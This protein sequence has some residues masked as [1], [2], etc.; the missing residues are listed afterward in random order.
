M[1]GN[2]SVT[3]KKAAKARS[4]EIDEQI[5]AESRRLKREYKVLV[6]GTDQPSLCTLVNQMK[7]IHQGGLSETELTAF[8]PVVHKN[9]MESAYEALK[10]MR[11]A[12]LN[13]VDRSNLVLA[14]KVLDFHVATLWDTHSYISLEIAEAINQLW[15][16]PI[17]PTIMD[18]L[19]GKCDSIDSV[20][21]FLSEV[22]R[23]GEPDYLPNEMDVLRAHHEPVGISETRFTMG[24]LAK[25]IHHFENVTSIIFCTALSDYDQVREGQTQTRMVESLLLLE[26]LTNAR[27][28]TR[29]SIILLFTEFDIF[30]NKLQRVPLDHYFPKYTGGTDVN[31]A[32]QYIRSKFVNRARGSAQSTVYSHVTQGTDNINIGLVFHMVKDTINWNVLK[33]KG[34][35]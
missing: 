12:G 26:S 27:W 29:T 1:G 14:D 2:I 25:W 18:D 33:D 28:F 34:L 30:K 8:R 15:K 22:L 35:I 32:T 10:H 6:M 13:W 24:Q 20:V 4:D 31:E 3:D 11:K 23:I 9:V 17:M 16:D 5:E 19:C 7:I 21:Y